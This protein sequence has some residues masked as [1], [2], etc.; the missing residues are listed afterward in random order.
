MC[1]GVFNED[2]KCVSMNGEIETQPVLVTSDLERYLRVQI[3]NNAIREIFLNQF[4]HMFSVYEYFFNQPNQVL[5]FSALFAF[6]GV[7]IL[8]SCRGIWI[9]GY[10]TEI[11]FIHLIKRLFYRINPDHIYGSCHVSW[12]VKCLLASLM[13]KFWPITA[14]TV[15]PFA[16]WMLASSF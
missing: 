2:T 16:C 9:L 3:V 8:L 14:N 1:V 12:K 11:K 5:L 15:T 10:Q 7:L 6:F 4:A 13:P